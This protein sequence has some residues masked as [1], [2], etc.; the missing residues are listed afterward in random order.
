MLAE[1]PD[2]STAPRHPGIAQGLVCT[3]N[4]T[5]VQPVD[6]YRNT[7]GSK[8]ANCIWRSGGDLAA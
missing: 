7:A 6:A 4:F 8:A 1:I 3:D 2:G 5:S